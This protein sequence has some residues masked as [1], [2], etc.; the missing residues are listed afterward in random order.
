M[1]CWKNVGE[2]DYHQAGAKPSAEL[3]VMAFSPVVKLE[4]PFG[5]KNTNL[6]PDDI[7]LA[8]SYLDFGETVKVKCIVFR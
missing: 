1:L 4:T 2:K 3:L 8:R 7:D 5:W 6:T